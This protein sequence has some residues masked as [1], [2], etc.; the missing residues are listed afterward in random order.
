MHATGDVDAGA[1]AGGTAVRGRLA[2]ERLRETLAAACAFEIDERGVLVCGPQ[3]EAN[4][5]LLRVRTPN[6]H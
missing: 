1:P 6:S 4:Q 2:R 5:K 3:G